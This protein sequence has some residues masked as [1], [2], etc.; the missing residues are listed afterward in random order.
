M[1]GLAELFQ[2]IFRIRTAPFVNGLE[3]IAAEENVAAREEAADDGVFD[4]AR[5]LHFVDGDEAEAVPPAL[6]AGVFAEEI[7]G[8]GDE[9][10]EV[11]SVVV[12]QD[13]CF[14]LNSMKFCSAWVSLPGA[15]AAAGRLSMIC[16]QSSSS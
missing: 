5:V 8:A 10:R 12:V 16:R 11:D 6:A 7:V 14:F 15:D 2:N 1:V 13:G 4:F 3:V 9:V